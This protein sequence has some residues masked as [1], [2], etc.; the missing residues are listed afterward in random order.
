MGR[1]AED[2][3]GGDC[4]EADSIRHRLECSRWAAQEHDNRER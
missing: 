1:R 2:E 3:R 4:L